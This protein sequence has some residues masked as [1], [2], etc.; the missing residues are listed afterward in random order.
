MSTFVRR[1][2]AGFAVLVL[3]AALIPFVGALP[4]GAELTGP[5]TDGP[6]YPNYGQPGGICPDGTD[7][8]SDHQYGSKSGDWG[9]ITANSNS[10]TVSANSGFTL[11]VCTKAGR[12]RLIYQ[13]TGTETVPTPD[14]QELS[15]WSFKVDSAPRCP[16]APPGATVV[17]FG[18]PVLLS[19]KESASKSAEITVNIPAGTYDIWLTSYD[20]HVTATGT[21]P[22]Q[23]QEQYHVVGSGSS[24]VVF[25]S[26]SISD[27]PDDQNQ[28][29]EQ[30]EDDLVISADLTGVTAVHSAY[31]TSGANSIRPVCAVFVPVQQTPTGS[32]T[33][34][35]KTNLET[36]ESFSFTLD[37]GDTQSV[38]SGGSYT[39][40]SLTGGTYDLSEVLTA[41]QISAGWAL[42]SI[43]C[44]QASVTVNGATVRISLAAG[45]NVT[46]TFHNALEEQPPPPPPSPPPPPE[47][48]RILIQKLVTPTT[49][50]GSFTFTASFHTGDLVIPA[51]G[52][53]DSGLLAPGSYTV[54]EVAPEG[55]GV[56]DL[57]C[58]DPDD[59]TVVSRDSNGLSA[60]ATIDL[61][62]GETVICTFTNAVVNVGG[63]QVTTTTTPPQGTQ[64]TLPFTGADSGSAAAL[65]LAV[66]ALGGMLL[67][68]GRREADEG[69]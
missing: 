1:R 34:E 19:N 6:Q 31:P 20:N 41:A 13:V 48:G 27:L 61:D 57:T 39:W 25:T 17:D 12:G 69:S 2:T 67:A 15:H 54:S 33:V 16:E 24:G 50:T 7:G 63:I 28:L 40:S 32:I 23:P 66:L 5:L 30:V 60:S 37:P 14:D 21:K 26:D 45:Q 59:G 62:G 18:S 52:T 55:W 4:A 43:D 36:T 10:L 44:G 3:L 68:L 58:S 46:C 42:S 29:T 35:K 38:A 56:S 65:G 64:V 8:W 47:Q 53:H 9:S 11:L 22:H 51:G 49:A